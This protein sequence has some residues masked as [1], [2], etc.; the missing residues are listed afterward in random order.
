MNKKLLATVTLL[1]ASSAQASIIYVL[2]SVTPAG[3]GSFDWRYSASLSADQRINTAISPSFAVIFDFLGVTSATTSNAVAGLT[4]NTFLE[5]TTTPQP[6]AQT[7][8]DSPTLQNIHTTITGSFTPTVLTSI[9]TIDV[10]STSGQINQRFLAQ[11]AQA[12]KNAAGT[13]ADGTLT[14]NTAQ[15][16][17]PSNVPEPATA[18]MIGMGLLCMGWVGSKR[19]QRS[20]STVRRTMAI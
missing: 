20:S 7:V 13:P 19:R 5:N 15:I 6:F 16:A 4:L 9:F 11:S 12:I 17:G 10:F 1:A 18:A 2:T 14:G 3:G 8:P